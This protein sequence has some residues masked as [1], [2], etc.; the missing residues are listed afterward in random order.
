M[1]VVHHSNYVRWLEEA[2]TFYFDDHDL[3]YVETERLGVMSP[4]I[5]IDLKYKYPAK[6]GDDFVVQINMIK[7]TGVRFCMAYTVMNQNGRILLE[8]ESG[9][10]FVDADLK[11]ISLSRALPERHDRMKALLEGTDD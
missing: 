1:G 8:G 11:P 7:Y 9:H 4:I 10:A 3:A 6:Y 2:R 5:D